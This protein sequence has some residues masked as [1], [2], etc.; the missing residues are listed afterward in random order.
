MYPV[1][2]VGPKVRV[3][4]AANC[5]VFWILPLD[6]NSEPLSWNYNDVP[7]HSDQPCSIYG[8]MW[9]GEGGSLPPFTLVLDSTPLVA[10]VFAFL[11]CV[12]ASIDM[13]CGQFACG[14]QDL[15]V[16]MGGTG[17]EYLQML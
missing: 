13:S 8:S 11:N 15:Q 17:C 5:A 1:T 10:I 9:R 2:P 4:T 16:R 7:S 3:V 12:F 6:P 14:M